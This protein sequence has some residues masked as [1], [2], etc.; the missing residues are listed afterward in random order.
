[1]GLIPAW[2]IWVISVAGV[3]GSMAESL[4]ADG[5]RLGGR[6]IEHDFA[7]AFNTFVGAVTAA[8][9]AASLALGR[10]YVPFES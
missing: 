6:R 9:I 10:I 5:A 4:L 3:A 7:N 8:E 2:G 1:V